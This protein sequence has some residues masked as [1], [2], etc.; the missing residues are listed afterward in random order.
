ME[1]LPFRTH[2]DLLTEMLIS[3][4]NSEINIIKGAY[5][6]RFGQSIESKV[7]GDLTAKTERCMCFPFN[8]LYL[9]FCLVLFFLLTPALVF[10]MALTAS[11]TENSYVD[12]NQVMA[13]VDALYQA[14][15]AKIGTDEITFCGILCARSQQH[16]AALSITYHQR[17]K[18]T[19]TKAIKKEL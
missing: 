15:Q 11:R 1:S 9:C 14:G 17:H 3:R 10:N 19:L 4:S 2:E 16:L 12:Q 8:Y 6:T 13:D 7:R 5:R 18:T